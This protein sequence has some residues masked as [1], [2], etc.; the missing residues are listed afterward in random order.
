MRSLLRV[1]E[2][3]STTQVYA[4]AVSSIVVTCKLKTF[5]I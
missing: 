2:S 1:A 5:K 4:Q 3:Y